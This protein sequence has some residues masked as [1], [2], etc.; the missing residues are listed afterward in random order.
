MR[1]LKRISFFLYSC[2]LFAGGFYGHM[3]LE[4]AF[5]PGVSQ[6]DL[7]AVIGSPD[8]TLAVTADVSYITCDTKLVTKKYDLQTG[9]VTES[10]GKIPEKYVGMGREQ[11]VDCLMDSIASPLLEERRQGLASAEVLSFSPEKIVIRKY[12][13]KQEPVKGYYLTVEENLVVVYEGNRQTLYLKTNIDARLLP[14]ELRA[15]I[16]HGWELSS[17]DELEKFLVPYTTS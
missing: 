4:A 12:Y 3:K 9:K 17:V 2:L 14:Q 6:K 1:H 5:Y 7:P 13:Q 11:F 10:T 15:Q 8:K 16:L